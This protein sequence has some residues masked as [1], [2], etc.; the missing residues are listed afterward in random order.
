MVTRMKGQ[1]KMARE[2]V[3]TMNLDPETGKV[4]MGKEGDELVNRESYIKNLR[5]RGDY[6]VEEKERKLY[7]Y[8]K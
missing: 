8:Y 2:L 6:E 4:R 7:V 1:S 3:W 5:L